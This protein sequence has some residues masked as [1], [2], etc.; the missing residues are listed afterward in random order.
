[1]TGQIKIWKLYNEY[2][3][4]GLAQ[5]ETFW[6]AAIRKLDLTVNYDREKLAAI[7]K[8]GALVIVANHPYGVLDGVILN[9]IV[10]KVRSDYKVLTNSVLCQA[11]DARANLLEINFSATEEALKTNLETRKISREILKNGGCIAV[12]PAGGV[13][14]I[15]SLKDKVAQDTEWQSFIGGLVQSAQTDVLPIFFEG[16]NSRLFQVVSLFSPTLR[17]SMFFKEVADKIGWTIGVRIGEVIPYSTMA[18]IKDR[19]EI[20]HFMRTETY[21]LGGMETLPPPKAAYRV[22]PNA[23]K[24]AKFKKK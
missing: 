15:P 11:E 10:S 17:L 12:F 9:H 5:G 13:S 6:D 22:D 21:K 20:C 19:A 18:H 4:E 3:R 23:H 14:T 7:P 8:T 16:Q 1:M 2:S 24:H